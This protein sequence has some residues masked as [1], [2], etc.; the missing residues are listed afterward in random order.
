MVS[1]A[2]LTLEDFLGVCHLREAQFLSHLRSHLC[3]V[4]V[5]GLA[6]ADNNVHV[7]YLLMAVARA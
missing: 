5:D 2:V 6:S 1:F 4:A 3:R 7:A